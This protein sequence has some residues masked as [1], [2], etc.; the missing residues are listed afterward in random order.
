MRRSAALILSATIVTSTAC[1]PAMR[2]PAAPALDARD[3]A[4]Y[5][6]VAESIYVRSTGGQPIGIVTTVLDTACA[7]S[8]CPPLAARWGVERVWWTQADTVTAGAA[9]QALLARAGHR[10]DVGPVALGRPQLVPVLTES[11]PF[12]ERD[13]SSWQSFRDEHAGAAGVLQF[14]PVGYDADGK[15]ALVYV[16]WECGP[17]C[18][19]GVAVALRQSDGGEWQLGDVLLVGPP[20]RAQPSA[21]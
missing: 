17:T 1:A 2:A 20:G 12:G 3:I 16:R 4:V 9:R 19:H 15:A 14:S 13:V 6:T 18:G 5:R 7:T 10:I 11:A 21:P 8:S